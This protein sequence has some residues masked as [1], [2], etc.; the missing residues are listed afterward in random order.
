VAPTPQQTCY[1]ASVVLDQSKRHN[2]LDAALT[3][4]LQH[5][6]AATSMASVASDASVSKPTVYNHFPSKQILFAAVVEEMVSRLRAEFEA[7]ELHGLPA[8]E[9][10]QRVAKQ[11]IGLSMDDRV[12]S[13]YRLIVSEGS[14]SSDLRRTVEALAESPIYRMLLD[15]LEV[16]VQR[17]ELRECDLN[18]AAST[19][20]VLVKGRL[21]LRA[22]LDPS[23]RPGPEV[24]FAQ[25][26]RGVKR[27]MTIF[28]PGSPADPVTPSRTEG[29]ATPE[30]VTTGTG[31]ARV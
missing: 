27:F 26:E 9:A 22:I 6:Y 10:L 15:L 1:S 17:G 23:S 14:G 13:L 30:I 21:F 12:V 28:G 2:I 25:A 29:N 3:L 24:Y 19:F 8:H 5:G 20:M 7:P 4:F 18:D 11:F 16:F 31:H